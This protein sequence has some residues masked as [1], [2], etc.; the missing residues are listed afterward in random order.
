MRPAIENA[1]QAEFIH[2]VGTEIR[3]FSAS[4]VEIRNLVSSVREEISWDT[5]SVFT[6]GIQCMIEFLCQY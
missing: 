4:I 5:Y 1:M 6:R 2:P 3:P